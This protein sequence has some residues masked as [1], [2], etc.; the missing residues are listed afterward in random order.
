MLT[1]FETRRHRRDSINLS[2]RPIGLRDY[3]AILLNNAA[4]SRSNAAGANGGLAPG[5][6]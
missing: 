1:H 2:Q 3:R 4:S 5:Q 6:R